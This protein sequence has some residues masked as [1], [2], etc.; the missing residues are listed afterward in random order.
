MSILGHGHDHR[1]PGLGFVGHGVH[2]VE[3]EIDQHLLDLDLISNSRRASGAGRIW[4]VTPRLLASARMMNSRPLTTSFRYGPSGATVKAGVSHEQDVVRLSIDDSGRGMS[5]TD[6]D[7]MGER[8][9]R[10]VGSGQDGSGLGWS[11]VRRIATVHRA[12]VRLGRSSLGGLS[13]EVRF[14]AERPL[15][16]C[17]NGAAGLTVPSGYHGFTS[18]GLCVPRRAALAVKTS[19]RLLSL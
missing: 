13:V 16:S 5:S 7:R 8:F 10:V 12:V 14:P 4:S 1:A 3:H 19:R 2:R 18:A 9:F 15:E 17:L 11:I 6:M